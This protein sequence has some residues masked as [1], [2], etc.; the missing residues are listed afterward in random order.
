MNFVVRWIGQSEDSVWRKENSCFLLPDRIR[1][2]DMIYLIEG[3]SDF[4]YNGEVK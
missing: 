3:S 2:L 1:I 4:H